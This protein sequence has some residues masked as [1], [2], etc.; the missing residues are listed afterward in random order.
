MRLL[1][2]FPYRRKMYAYSQGDH[3]GTFVFNQDFVK[4]AAMYGSLDGIDILL[5]AYPP[6][7]KGG[8]DSSLEELKRELSGFPLSIRPVDQLDNLNN[9]ESI[10]FT[11]GVYIGPIT[12]ARS[13]LPAPGFP[14][15]TQIHSIDET[16]I[17][18]LYAAA[19]L[20][21]EPG[22]AIIVSSRA[23]EVSVKD[24]FDQVSS[25]LST[26]C[27]PAPALSALIS[28]IPLGVDADFLRPLSR[29]HARQVLGLPLN[30][31]IILC[32]GRLSDELKADLEPLLWVF[33]QLCCKQ[34]M[35]LL[36]AGSDPNGYSRVIEARAQELGIADR[37]KLILNFPYFLKPT[38]YS[39]ADVCVAPSDNIQETFGLSITEAM[40][41]GLPV[42]ASD[43]SGYRD[44]VVD[45]DTGYLIP[46]LWPDDAAG[47]L[48]LFGPLC[49]YAPRR[50]YLARHTPL[51]V[52]ILL[53]R[54]RSIIENPQMAAQMGNR[55]RRRVLEQYSWKAVF[56]K[57]LELWKEQLATRARAGSNKSRGNRLDYSRAFGEFA[58]SRSSEVFIGIGVRD[59]DAASSKRL[60]VNNETCQEILGACRGG[61]KLFSELNPNRSSEFDSAIMALLKGGFLRWNNRQF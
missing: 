49:T 40:A 46:T 15:A 47:R 33:S 3:D 41:C 6:T 16:F 20:T 51:D 8:W 34:P 42:I 36:I 12:Q 56:P 58:T 25:G 52:A 2:N 44:L 1:L 50:H 24:L 38:I 9:N 59:L 53:D 37:I 4:A 27:R 39:A 45:S 5:D 26:S 28:R 57:H 17:L 61:A 18:F 60:K 43:W 11:A 10:F 13:A 23:G 48:S 7:A 32:V 31:P 55:G 21:F 22:D 14:V 54:L 35:N 30:E 19:L 29:E